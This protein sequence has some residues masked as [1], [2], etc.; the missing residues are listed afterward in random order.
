MRVYPERTRR[1]Q[2][3]AEV[4]DTRVKSI[5]SEL[6]DAELHVDPSRPPFANREHV[7]FLSFALDRVGPLKGAR[8]LEVGC[9]T[10][11]LSVYLALQGAVVD[12]IDISA[13]NVALANRRAQV[14]GVAERATFRAVPVENLDDPDG[15]Y[16]AVIGNQVLHHFQLE[17]AMPNLKR[18]L[19]PG[20]AAVFC[21]PVLFVPNALRKFRNGRL[22]TRFFPT[23]VDTP[24]ERSI[25]VADLRL[26]K[27]TFPSMRLHPFQ[28]LTRTQNFVELSDPWFARFSRFDHAVLRRVPASRRFCRYVVCDLEPDPTFIQTKE[29]L[30]IC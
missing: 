4:Y 7:D 26:I 21:E 28:M 8:I 24:T 22:V 10:G 5:F 17:Q 25:S 1:Q 23:R 6:S 2:V 27:A 18:M 30:N 9:G 14:N 16:D 20:G 11:A 29:L 15:A 13:E 12:A 19:K 3:E